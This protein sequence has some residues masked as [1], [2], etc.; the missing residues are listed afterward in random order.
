M[1][2]AASDTSMSNFGDGMS[3]ASLN[4]IK[5]HGALDQDG[6]KVKLRGLQKKNLFSSEQQERKIR[7]QI[8]EKDE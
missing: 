8:I 3:D 1:N 2:H 6:E 5:A 7:L 4:I